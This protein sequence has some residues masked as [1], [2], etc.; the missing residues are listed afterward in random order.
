[1]KY[2]YGVNEQTYKLTSIRSKDF[3]VSIDS[4]FADLNLM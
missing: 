4:M 3:E 2:L 1:M